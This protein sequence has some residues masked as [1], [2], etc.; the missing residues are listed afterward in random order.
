MNGNSFVCFSEIRGKV[1]ARTNPSKV[2]EERTCGNFRTRSI[3]F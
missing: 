2:N 3:M 1:E